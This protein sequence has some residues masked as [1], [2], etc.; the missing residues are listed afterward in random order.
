VAHAEVADALI[1]IFVPTLVTAAG[2]V[3]AA[4]SAAAAALPQ[5]LALATVFMV[6]ETLDLERDGQPIPRFAF[7]EDAARAIGHAARYGAWRSAPL[8][9]VPTFPDV[10]TIEA[11]TVIAHALGAGTEWLEGQDVARLLDCYGIATPPARFVNDALAAEAAA[12]EIGGP[13]ALKAIAPGLLHK[14]DAGAVA[15]GLEPNEVKGA[16]AEMTRRVA[17]AGFEVA[18]FHVQA[19]APRGV[20]LIVGVVQDR[21]F[22]PLI[23]AGAGGTSTELLGDVQARLTPLTDLDAQDMLRSLRLFPL[24]DGYRG[25]PRCDIAALEELLLRV[26]ALVEAHP[27]VAEMDLNPVIALPSGA[28]A[29]DARI[30]IETA[31]PPAIRPSL[32]A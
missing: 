2:D 12:A 21:A 18:G 31:P 30:R 6:D 25:A 22:G 29:I 23:A 26:S 32:R 9:T 14:S 10:D 7:P 1:V 24:L 13:V 4:V 27:E 5:E 11:G 20:E 19:M 3:A 15:I 8:G 16:A 17:A 28:L